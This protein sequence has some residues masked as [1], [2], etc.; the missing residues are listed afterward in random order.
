MLIIPVFNKAGKTTPYVCIALILINAFIYFFIQS[1]DSQIRQEAYGYYE[2][3]GLMT[4]ELKAYQGYL[5]QK[6]N[7]VP[8]TIPRNFS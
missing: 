2:T 8:E 6:G 1:G 3:S 7:N 4:L 5:Q